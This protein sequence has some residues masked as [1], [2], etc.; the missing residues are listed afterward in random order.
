[1][2]RF[3]PPFKSI[4]LPK[5]TEDQKEGVAHVVLFVMLLA[6]CWVSKYV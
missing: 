1:M 4:K 2:I 5:L 3:I 6:A